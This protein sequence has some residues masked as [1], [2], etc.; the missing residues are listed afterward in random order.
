[1]PQSCG[2]QK[3]SLA[4]ILSALLLQ[5]P[6]SLGGDVRVVPVRANTLGFFG[7]LF[8]H[9]LLPAA[10]LSISNEGWTEH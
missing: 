7:W 1:M 5:C 8:L 2:V 3:T 6:L 9:S 4:V 10:V